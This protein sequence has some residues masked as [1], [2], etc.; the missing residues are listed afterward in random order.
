MNG[1]YRY[2]ESKSFYVQSAS[3]AWCRLV[4]LTV[5]LTLSTGLFAQ[6]NTPCDSGSLKP[7]AGAGIETN[8]YK[9]CNIQQLQN[10]TTLTAHYVLVTDIDASTTKDLNGDKGFAP[11]GATYSTTGLRTDSPGSP[12]FSGAFDGGGY[13]ISNLFIDRPVEEGVGLFAFPRTADIKNLTFSTAKVT[14]R[15]RVGILAGHAQQST[16]SRITVTGS[17]VT[18]STRVGTRVGTLAGRAVHGTISDIAVTNSVVAGGELVG[19]VIGE[20]SGIGASLSAARVTAS[21]ITGQAEVGGVA[22]Y[23]AD[24]RISTVRVTDSTIGA[25]REGGG[26]AGSVGG[27][28]QGSEAIGIVVTGSDEAG[29]KELGGLVGHLIEVALLGSLMRR[30]LLGTRREI[31]RLEALWVMS[32]EVLL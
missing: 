31:M 16:I 15:T 7:N 19:G 21:T 11:I 3:E 13:R 8:P 4:L 26:V 23:L 30:G 9:I 20:F 29:G 17:V 2:F 25:E 10:I 27:G 32:G 6:D 24:A 1:S 14:G 12:G 5:C 28:I 18:G 22:G